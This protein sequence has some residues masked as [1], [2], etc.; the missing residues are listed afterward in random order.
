MFW[1]KHKQEVQDIKEAVSGPAPMPFPQPVQAADGKFAPLFVK[2]DRY[3]EILEAIAKLKGTLRNIDSILKTKQSI[4]K[5]KEDANALLLRQLG[6]CAECAQELN[7]A[8][9]KPAALD[10]MVVAQPEAIEGDMQQIS[11]RLSQLSDQL[12]QIG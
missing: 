1:S 9:A 2:V 11:T 4:S 5:L 12:Q 10:Q 3:K 8:F 7:E 6:V